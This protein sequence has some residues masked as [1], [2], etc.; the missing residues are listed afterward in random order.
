MK[1]ILIVVVFLMFLPN[2]GA[3]IISL[4]S[5]GSNNIIINPD[6]YIEGFFT[7]DVVA[8]APVCGNNVTEDGEECDDGN[9]EN[10]DECRNDC[11]LPY[12][13]DG[14]EDPDEECDDGNQVGGDGCD[15]N[16]EIEE[17]ECVVD[18]DCGEGHWLGEDEFCWCEKLF[19][20]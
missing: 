18:E 6:A 17:G 4:N 1:K 11:T 7:G 5:G 10:E 3:D 20:Y 15:E 19:D 2:I 13:G 16:C 8:G 14:I 9:L 12:C